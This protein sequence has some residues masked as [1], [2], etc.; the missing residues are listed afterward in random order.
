MAFPPPLRLLRAGVAMMA[1]VLDAAVCPAAEWVRVETPNF[2]VFGESGERRTREIAAE[3]ERFREALGRITVAQ[4][5]TAVPT[6]V[7]VFA[8]QSSFRQY[9]PRYND[10]IVEVAGYFVGTDAQNVIALTIQEREQAL[11][12]IFHEY[13]HLVLADLLRGV[14][15]WINEG[16]AEYYSTFPVLGGPIPSHL[17]LLNTSALMP[18]AELLAVDDSSP[19]YNEGNRRSLFYAQ[20]WALVHM[21]LSAE[22]SRYDDLR[23]FLGLTTAGEQSVRAWQNVFGTRDMIPELKGYAG[24]DRMIAHRFRGV[25]EIETTVGPAIPVSSSDVHAVLGD[26][27]RFTYAEEA[28]AHLERAA[29]MQPPSALARALLGLLKIRQNQEEAARA[30]LTEAA[31][32]RRDW[33]VQ[34]H[35]GIGFAELARGGGSIAT[36]AEASRAALEAVAATRPDLANV[37]AVQATLPGTSSTQA[38]R[39]LQR[40]RQL[41]TGRLEYAIMEAQALANDE[42]FAM[43]RGVLGP[44][45]SS[46]MPPDIRERARSLMGRIVA[47][48]RARAERAETDA[49]RA[50]GEPVLQDAAVGTPADSRSST[51]PRIVPDYRALRAGEQRVEGTLQRIECSANGIVLHLRSEDGT[52]GFP[53]PALA[54]VLFISYRDDLAGSVM[55]GARNPPDRVYLTYRPAPPGQ[56]GSPGTVVAV[57]FLPR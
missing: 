35:V 40:A 39:L 4:G 42:Q 20:S 45:M 12:T 56:A 16:L 9:R 6:I 34:Y 33:L 10:K 31:V 54:D 51:E 32:E 15:T 19:L 55:C 38:V 47:R 28:P 48:E 2:V 41:A 17:Y 44:L 8:T 46:R 24:R 14:P 5:K 27:L 1:V 7:V 25:R 50:A 37:Y 26:L 36:D 52:E 21:L 22:P 23:T 11:R 43:A 30:L 29:A 13:S 49:A 18:L 3:F 53:A 57:E